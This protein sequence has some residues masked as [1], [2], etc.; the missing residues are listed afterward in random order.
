LPYHAYMKLQR[1]AL[2]AYA[3]ALL[4]LVGEASS[5]TAPEPQ[6]LARV[7]AESPGADE[8]E[9][10]LSGITPTPALV[11]ALLAQAELRLGNRLDDAQTLQALAER[12]ARANG[13]RASI[14]AALQ[15]RG[16]TLRLRGDVPGARALL[17]EGL[18]LARAATA[19][20]VEARVLASL[21]MVTVREGQHATAIELLEQS[22]RLFESLGDLSGQALAWNHLGAVQV[23]LGQP[24]EAL[25]RY[26]HALS[27]ARAAGDTRFEARL[28]NAIGLQK[29]YLGHA[30][31]ALEYISEAL[32]QFESLDDRRGQVF[33]LTY[34]GE[35]YARQGDPAQ[36]LAHC[37]RSL[38]LAQELGLKKDEAN[39]WGNI[40]KALGLSQE[41]LQAREA[42]A[43]A[44]TLF[45]ALGDK[46]GQAATA[47]GVGVS[48]RE[49]GDCASA[50][51]FFERART[52][53]EEVGTSDIGGM[54]LV[55][56]AECRRVR[57]DPARAVE[58]ARQAIE[59]ARVGGDPEHL[60]EALVTA[61]R[62]QQALGEREAARAAFQEAIDLTEALRAD[63]AGGE[64]A[65]QGFLRERALPYI[66][67]AELLIAEQRPED[68]LMA[69][70]RGKSRTLLDALRRGRARIDRRLNPAEREAERQQ[71]DTLA[72]LGTELR[73]ERQR[74]TPDPQ[75]I[76]VLEQRL[77]QARLSRE[78]LMTRLFGA[79]P[80]LRALR[81]EAPSL[82][83]E[84]LP[85]L[86]LDPGTALLEYVV[87]PSEAHLL[88]LTRDAGVTR[89][90]SYGL[91]AGPSLARDARQFR[92]RLAE[93]DL[94][95]GTL[96]RQLYDRLLKPAHAQ[97]AGRRQL[98]IV[99]DGVLWELPF[100]ALMPRPGSYLVEDCSLSY[101]PSLTVLREMRRKPRSAAPGSLLALANPSLGETRRRARGSLALMGGLSLQPLP[102]AESQVRALQS[103][104][105]PRNS[106]VYIGQ[107]AREARV[108]ALSG[109][110]GVLHFATHGLLNDE[111]PLY[112]Q[113]VLAE[114]R[115][116]EGE[117]GLLE[118]R[119]ILELDLDADLA[120]LSACET[121]RGRVSAGEG[122]IGM[123][124][125]FFV[126]G[127]PTTVVSQWKVETA[128][129]AALMVAFHRELR[130]GRGRA[131][132]LQRAMRSLLARPGWRHPFYWA[133]FAVVGDG[134]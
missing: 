67:L 14:A 124:W 82:Q 115:P 90:G 132:A 56:L 78:A 86:L 52:L 54:A 68:A 93:R 94:G 18:E 62:A 10:R 31:E 50:E 99:P 85:A 121:G 89:V 134:S 6:D 32:R 21:G 4:S 34:L 131:A 19:R 49:L 33:A 20:E 59:V 17:E 16:E 9:A 55:D 48:Y 7:L 57:G 70:E 26:E 63:L 113:L 96:A 58:L 42:Y 91:A 28:L 88:V 120:V 129:T 13:D 46:R 12:L 101:A 36:S 74:R 15:A 79:H 117:D 39:S 104:Y 103:L 76:G 111:N 64:Q 87:G 61:G 45:E 73:R 22:L 125:A 97:L 38:A 100:Q 30:A 41:L 130:A 72:E 60:R 23:L 5:Q 81:G 92:Q 122:L 110:R 27:L 95:A 47:D 8:R 35:L 126:A 25:A 40:G 24:E 84:D 83:M 11:T 66:A 3:L 75:Q 1:H 80:A 102:E 105:G 37:R 29:L 71:D 109:H 123:S 65:Q 106:E 69:A 114:P 108:K 43:H 107:E 127:C 53:A 51:P 128:S 98:V 119:E 44:L 133:G 118:A 112:S 77:A 2:W 116:G